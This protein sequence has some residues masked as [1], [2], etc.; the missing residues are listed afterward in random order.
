MTRRSPAAASCARPAT[1]SEAPPTFHPREFARFD[2]LAEVR[3]CYSRFYSY[4]LTGKQVSGIL[5]PR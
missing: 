2:T 3:N 5:N 1:G 4:K